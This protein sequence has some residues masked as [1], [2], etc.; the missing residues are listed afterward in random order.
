M[1]YTAPAILNTKSAGNGIGNSHKRPSISSVKGDG[2][3]DNLGIQSAAAYEA[4]S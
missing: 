2:T 4:N 1:Q 3:P